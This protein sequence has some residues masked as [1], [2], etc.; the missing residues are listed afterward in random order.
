M[1]VN[2]KENWL[3]PLG[4]ALLVLLLLLSRPLDQWT[5]ALS[6]FGW[7]AQALYFLMMACSL[8]M[9]GIVRPRHSAL[10]Y[11]LPLAALS[12]FYWWVGI[13]KIEVFY[14]ASLGRLLLA[15]TLTAGIARA[16]RDKSL[17]HLDLIAAV[18]IFALILLASL[19]NYMHKTPHTYGVTASRFNIA[20]SAVLYYAWLF[21]VLLIP[22]LRKNRFGG[23]TLLCVGA[24]GLAL[25]LASAPPSQLWTYVHVPILKYLLS[26]FILYCPMFTGFVLGGLWCILPSGKGVREKPE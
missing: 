20:F 7:L 10:T 6:G 15:L 1:S 26:A 23:L 21:G 14:P 9:L 16:M 25:H 5:Q 11:L 8:Y 4:A 2:R 17:G 22:Y 24:T 12:F 18:H 13:C 3:P 19:G